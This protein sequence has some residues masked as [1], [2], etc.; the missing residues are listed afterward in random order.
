MIF[1]GYSSHNSLLRIF[2]GGNTLLWSQTG[3]EQNKSQ[4]MISVLLV[5]IGSGQYT[6]RMIW[7][8]GVHR[9]SCLMDG[10]ITFHGGGLNRVEGTIALV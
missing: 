7:I 8:S 2:A 3:V 5:A 1:D 4:D 10:R 6:D 9:N